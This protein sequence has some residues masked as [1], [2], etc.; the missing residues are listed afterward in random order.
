MLVRVFK[1]EQM[2]KWTTSIEKNEVATADALMQWEVKNDELSFWKLEDENVDQAALAWTSNRDC[3]KGVFLIFL[4]ESYLINM[5]INVDS[6]SPGATPV[7]DLKEK[8]CNLVDLDFWSMGFL[9]EHLTNQIK[10]N[11]MKYLCESEIK[12]LFKEAIESS[13][14]PIEAL[15]S[16]LQKNI[17]GVN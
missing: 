1:Q 7:E 6:T 15:K 11:K 9:S 5:N 4:D 12:N 13:R 3:V 10:N 2:D 16:K 14:V 17:G 8:H